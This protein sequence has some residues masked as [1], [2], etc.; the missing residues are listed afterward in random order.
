[1]LKVRYFITIIAYK[2]TFITREQQMGSEIK[3]LPNREL[4]SLFSSDEHTLSEKQM[5]LLAPLLQKF[6]IVRDVRTCLVGS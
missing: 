4:E 5:E 6:G 1:M 2:I 3:F